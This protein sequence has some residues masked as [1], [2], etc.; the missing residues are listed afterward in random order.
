V[1]DNLKTWE[2]VSRVPKEHL[3]PFDKGTFKGTAIKPM[4]FIKTM[5][6][7]AGPAGTGWEVL[8]PD[9]TTERAGDD[10]LVFCT[11]GVKLFGSAPVYGV[12][13]DYLYRAKSNRSDDE[14][15]KKAYTDALT[16]ALVKFGVGADIH[17]GLWDGNKYVDEKPEE[18]PPPTYDRNPIVR[19]AFM[20]VYQE[21]LKI[22]EMGTLEDV[23][24]FWKA[25][26]SIIKALP[27]D[28][29]AE[30]TAKKDEIKD[31]LQ[32]RAA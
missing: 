27:A 20:E 24:S 29:L 15:Y 10:I 16:N 6:E 11:V 13:G 14:A 30:L 12:G 23:A 31:S 25:K 22:G 5:T 28:W 17:M 7:L 26:A 2:Q 18:K 3:K 1:S 19:A 8:K 21:L 4:W 9:F 32:Q